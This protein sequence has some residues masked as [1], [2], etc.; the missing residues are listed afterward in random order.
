MPNP[1]ALGAALIL[2]GV[3]IAPALTV[4]N[5]IV[6]RIIPTTM[7]NEAYTWIVTV[8]VAFSCSA[9]RWPG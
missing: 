8:S 5:S 6:G 7:L 4:Q 2:G 9:A 3:A 1:F